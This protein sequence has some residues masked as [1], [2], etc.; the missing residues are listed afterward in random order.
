M[1][2][3]G[4]VS[5]KKNIFIIIVCILA[6]GLISGCSKTFNK[7]FGGSGEDRAV[8][9][10]HTSDGG[11]IL[12]GI[13][14][15]F[16]AGGWDFWLIKTD[17]NGNKVWDKTFGGSNDDEA[18]A[19]QQTSD[20][21]YIL[22]GRTASFGAGGYDAW[23]IKTDANGNKV[24]DKTFGG[25]NYDWATAVQQTSDGGYILAGYTDSFGAGGGDAWLIKTDADGNEVWDKTFGGT[26]TDGAYAMQQ[27]SDGGYILAGITRSSGAGDFDAWLIKTDENGNKVWDTTFG[28]SNED[29]AYA[30]Q[31]TSDSGYILAGYTRS[32]G[33]GSFDGWLI[34]TDANGNKVWDKTFKGWNNDYAFAVQQTSDGGYILAGITSS[35]G[36]GGYDAWL[37]K[38][39]ADGNEVWDKTFGGTDLDYAYAVQ[40]TS[41]SG[42]ILAG[43]T[44]SFGVGRTDAWLIKTDAKGNAPATPT[45]G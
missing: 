36:A 30:V 37:I 18:Y 19:V 32:F 9:V 44:Y 24:W 17:A 29:W 38:T 15:S 35:I 6:V 21:G 40:Q 25:S 34:K 8:S 13:T 1:A 20:G 45:P 39:D 10:Q 23:L 43:Y 28:G 31:Q 26:N 27:T 4:E 11:Y 16:G 3:Q 2:Q 42:Y 33:S 7:T 22:A 14:A 5:M 12:A 41:D